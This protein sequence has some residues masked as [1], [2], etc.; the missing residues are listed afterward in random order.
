[1]SYREYIDFIQQTVP[2]EC[3][4]ENLGLNNNSNITADQNESS[5]FLSDMLTLQ[6]GKLSEGPKVDN[7]SADDLSGDSADIILI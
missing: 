5:V 4:P 6:G 3:H 7:C 2:I 1:M